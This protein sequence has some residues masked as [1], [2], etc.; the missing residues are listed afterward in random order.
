MATQYTIL[1]I[2]ENGV[3]QAPIVQSHEP[4][5]EQLQK[6]VGGLIEYCPM[7]QGVGF[8]IVVNEEGKLNGMPVNTTA[9]AMYI[10]TWM[11][12]HD[13]KELSQGKLILNGPVALVFVKEESK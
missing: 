10:E 7:P 8:E 3:P 13:P 4:K 1:P 12:K 5:L 9:S 2:A 6:L 11:S